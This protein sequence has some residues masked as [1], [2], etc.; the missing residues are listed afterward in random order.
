MVSTRKKV[1]SLK[2]NNKRLRLVNHQL[3]DKSKNEKVFL[4]G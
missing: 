3:K 1:D 2:K 4:V